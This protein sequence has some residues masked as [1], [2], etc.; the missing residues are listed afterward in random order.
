M[1]IQ[2]EETHV[3]SLL[4]IVHLETSHISTDDHIAAMQ[5]DLIDW[6]WNA[7]GGFAA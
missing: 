2:R 7:F 1:E 5:I 3:R 4:C 6:G